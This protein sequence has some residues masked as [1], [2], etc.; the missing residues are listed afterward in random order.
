ME[1]DGKELFLPKD[2]KDLNNSNVYNLDFEN[3]KIENN[4]NFNKWKELMNELYREQR[5]I[6]KCP[7]K[8][9]YICVE[10]NDEII[11]CPS[12]NKEICLFCLN[13][14]TNSWYRRC[15]SKRKLAIMHANG[16]DYSNLE[17]RRNSNYYDSEI[18]TIMF[19]IPGISLIFLIG[20]FD[21]AF[22]YKIVRKHYDNIDYNS[23]YEE[24]LREKNRIYW[25][26]NIAINGFTSIILVIPFFIFNCFI[27]ILLLLLII[28]RE[29][30]Y[31]YLIGFLHEDWYFLNKNLKKLCCC[32]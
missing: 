23:T 10:P 24:L 28:I 12:C 4:A 3:Q 8:N 16:I 5:K 27:S 14:F 18:E 30:W 22:F 7:F 17:D 11:K 20:I 31:M 21:N 19:F 25:A 29:K 26:I 1:N 15:C 6:Y 32:Y 13:E 9:H 2:K